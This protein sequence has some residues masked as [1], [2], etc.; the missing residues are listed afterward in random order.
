M[1]FCCFH[2]IANIIEE[3]KYN[4]WVQSMNKAI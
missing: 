1:A 3:E 2:I 4:I